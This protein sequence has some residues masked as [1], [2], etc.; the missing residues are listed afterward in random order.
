MAIIVNDFICNGNRILILK[1]KTR[2][3]YSAKVYID[4]YKYKWLLNNEKGIHYGRRKFLNID[5][6]YKKLK[7][8]DTGKEDCECTGPWDCQCTVTLNMYY[9]GIDKNDTKR[10]NHVPKD[11]D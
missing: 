2:N 7:L 6:I 1:S 8:L 3:N 10:N 9:K 5:D 4:K 11:K